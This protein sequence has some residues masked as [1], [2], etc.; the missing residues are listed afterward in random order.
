MNWQ[1]KYNTE[2]HNI[3][4]Q[5]PTIFRHIYNK[6]SILI[7]QYKSTLNLHLLTIYNSIRIYSVNFSYK[8]IYICIYI[9]IYIYI[10]YLISI[11]YIIYYI[12]I[13]IYI[14]IYIYL[15]IYSSIKNAIS[16]NCLIMDNPL[17]LCNKDSQCVIIN[18]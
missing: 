16:A 8:L 3:L 2:R 6:W 7:I 14:Y 5:I 11:I 10:I 18:I 1:K 15:Y 9:Y 13:Y 4:F 17:L 12:S